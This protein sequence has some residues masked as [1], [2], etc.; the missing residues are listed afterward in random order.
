ME[1][2]P[3]VVQTQQ[4]TPRQCRQAV[5]L[6]HKMQPVIQEKFLR[7]ANLQPV[8]RHQPMVRRQ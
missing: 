6:E 4:L 1:T 7:V 3:L 5:H 2:L 8:A